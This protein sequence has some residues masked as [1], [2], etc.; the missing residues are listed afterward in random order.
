MQIRIGQAG[1]W[2]PTP[3]DNLH[4]APDGGANGKTNPEAVTREFPGGLQEP[5]GYAVSGCSPLTPS[6]SVGGAAPG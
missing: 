6:T 5:S 2:L 3:D 4:L 1:T